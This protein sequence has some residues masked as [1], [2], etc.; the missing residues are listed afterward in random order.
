MPN[1]QQYIGTMRVVI[2]VEDELDATLTMDRLERE[3]MDLLDEE[4]G[5]SVAVTQVL[6]FTTD[7]TPEE[8]LNILKRARNALIK[9]RIKECYDL[10]SALDQQIFQLALSQDPTMPAQYDY[11]RMLGFVEAIFKRKGEPNE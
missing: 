1:L 11:S 5:D 6:P 2:N 10:A 3:C 9:T 4:E 7:V 8:V